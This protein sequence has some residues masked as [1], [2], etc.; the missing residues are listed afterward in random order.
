MEI[1]RNGVI[2]VYNVSGEKI[3][4]PKSEI[5]LEDL[6]SGIYLLQEKTKKALLSK[7]LLYGS[8]VKIRWDIY[9][10]KIIVID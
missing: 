6:A 4:T 9:A 10:K 8:G 7:K 5:N 2:E 1:T 3:F